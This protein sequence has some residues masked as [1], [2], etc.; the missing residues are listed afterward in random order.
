[1]QEKQR[2]HVVI[3]GRVQ[4]VCFRMETQRTAEST[5]VSGWV[6]NRPDGAVEAVFEGDRE[7]VD[8]M[9]AWCRRGPAHANV[10]DVEVKREPYAGEFQGFRI[11]Y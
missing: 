10:R 11:V 8:Q 7:G 1:M 3:A 2:A 9:L 6:R 4:G 5:G